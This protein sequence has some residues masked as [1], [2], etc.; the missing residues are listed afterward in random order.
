M[1]LAVWVVGVFG[2]FT[3]IGGAMGYF[4]AKSTASLI[5]GAVSGILLLASAYGMAE[6]MGAAYTVVL[7]VS[8]LLGMRFLKTW[9]KNHRLMP[10]LVMV[11]FSIVAFL[12]TLLELCQM[13]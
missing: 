13:P 9:L 6:N 12:L 1:N 3:L 10:D 11:F 7:V 5:A 2:L 8:L 4:K